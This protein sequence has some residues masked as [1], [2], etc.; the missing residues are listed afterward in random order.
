MIKV[1]GKG[2]WEG[3]LAIGRWSKATR[4]R[5]EKRGEREIRIKLC[6]VQ[7]PDNPD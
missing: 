2:Q 5:S 3:S 7:K 1:D 6:H 4:A